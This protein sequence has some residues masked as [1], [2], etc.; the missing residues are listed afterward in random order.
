MD[1]QKPQSDTFALFVKAVEGAM[2]RHYGT[3]LDFG[4]IADGKGSV[5]WDVETIHVLTHDEMAKYGQ[6]YLREIEG[7]RLVKVTREDWMKQRKERKAKAKEA[8]EEVAKKAAK[9]AAPSEAQAPTEWAKKGDS[10]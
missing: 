6:L 1:K 2:V 10:R 3:N 9:E 4:V 5:V 7:K 8:A